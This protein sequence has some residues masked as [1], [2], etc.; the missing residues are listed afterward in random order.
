MATVR[1]VQ[2]VE[3]SV[4][5]EQVERSKDGRAANTRVDLSQALQ[6]FVS[7][8]RPI[9]LLNGIDDRSARTG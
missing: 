9:G 8:E 3:D 1:L 7:G 4:L 6:Q 5:D 2:S